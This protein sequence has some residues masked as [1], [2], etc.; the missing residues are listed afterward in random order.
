VRGTAPRPFPP[1]R[2]CDRGQNDGSSAYTVAVIGDGAFTGGMVHEALN[3]IKKQLNL[4]IIINENEMSISKNIGRFAR[5]LSRLR[6]R[7][8]YFRT[9]KRTGAF[10]RKIPF[11]GRSLFRR[12]LGLKKT[13][14]KYDLRL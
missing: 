11:V 14:K 1:P 3:N 7:P 8:G 13:L 5:N 10:L 9:K 4:I 12:V 2:L 6:A